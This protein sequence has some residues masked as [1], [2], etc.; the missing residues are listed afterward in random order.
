MIDA[1]QKVLVYLCRYGRVDLSYWEQE[2]VTR[3]AQWVR[4][5]GELLKSEAPAPPDT[6]PP[7]HGDA[8]A[9]KVLGSSFENDYS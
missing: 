6:P 2:P 3:V 9:A 1:D 8:G 5:V 4:L 7:D